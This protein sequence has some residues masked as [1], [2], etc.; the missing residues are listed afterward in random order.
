MKRIYST[1][2]AAA[3]L[4]TVVFLAS[5]P[6]TNSPRISGSFM[7]AVAQGPIVA[8]RLTT[9]T[10]ANLGAPA[11]SAVRYCSDCAPS[12]PCAGAGTGAV[13]M[14]VAG[15]WICRPDL[16]AAPATSLAITGTGGA[17]YVELADQASAP[18]TP[19]AAIRLFSNASNAFA[20]KPASGFVSSFAGG[21][22][23][24]DR[25][26]TT[27]DAAGTMLVSTAVTA[28]NLLRQQANGSMTSSAVSDDGTT[29]SSTRPISAQHYHGS[30]T[31]P[32]CAVGGATIAG[33]GAT[34]EITTGGRDAGFEFSMTF[35]SGITATG[36]FATVTFN[37]TWTNNPI[38]SVTSS[39]NPNQGSGPF[40]MGNSFFITTTAT[41]IVFTDAITGNVPPPPDQATYKWFVICKG[42]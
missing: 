35:G 19:T 30:G 12:S 40:I 28:N 6:I 38:C 33:T 20:W 26:W 17:G 21:N 36:T 31:A 9:T 5:G 39:S 24:A 4:L 41:T 10:F 32:T 22:L 11:N 29:V 27:P 8:S 25:N 42:R 2:A 1:A 13:A 15:A 3:C 34:C 37:S 18:A 7:S 16:G 23:T 14:R